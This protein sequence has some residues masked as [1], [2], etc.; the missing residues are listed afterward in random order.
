MTCAST[1]AGSTR[2]VAPRTVNAHR[3]VLASVFAD[4]A[5]RGWRSGNPATAVAKRRQPAAPALE[6]FT[7]EQ[8][9]A[10]ALAA[11]GELGALIIVAA[12]TGLRRGEL[13]A[14]RW[15]DVRFEQTAL[16]VERAVSDGQIRRP[17]SGKARI[18]PLADRPL[19]VLR[20]LSGRAYWTDPDDLVFA[21]A[22]GGMR[23]PDAVSQA[24]IRAR[25]AA[26]APALRFHDLRHT[27]GTRMIAKADIRRVQEWMGHADVATTMK[28]LHYVERPDEAELVAAAFA[29][30]SPASGPPRPHGTDGVSFGLP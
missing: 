1:C 15:R 26:S 22:D 8:V 4:A 11:G 14:L 28:Y 12:M 29:V 27:F 25:D 13:V 20:E 16:H 5:A 2:K 7:A 10:I 6:V 19:A 24:Y 23:H 17:K 30:E 3:Q 18:V 9:E 21:R